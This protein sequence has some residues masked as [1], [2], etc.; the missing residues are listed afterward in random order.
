VAD[1]GHTIVC[2]VANIKPTQTTVVYEAVTLGSFFCTAKSKTGAQIASY[3]ELTV[4]RKSTG[5]R[6]QYIP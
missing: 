5:P 1:I 3:P 6:D 2:T 4:G